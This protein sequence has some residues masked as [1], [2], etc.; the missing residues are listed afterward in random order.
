MRDKVSAGVF[1]DRDGVINELIFNGDT[2]EFEPPHSPYDLHI[3]PFA[4]ESLKR[5]SAGNYSLFLVSNQPDYAKGKTTL[6]NLKS[7]HS[8]LHKNLSEN[9]VE[10]KEYFYCYHHPDGVVVKYTKRC[11]CRKPS[12]FFLEKA[13]RKYSIDLKRSWLIGDRDTDI[14][15][16]EE[17]GVRSIMVNYEHSAGYRGNSSPDYQASNL[18]EAVNIILSS[19]NKIEQPG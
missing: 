5:L 13:E 1:L 11:K 3:F 2:S 10:F 9:G 8:A 15:M 7:V 16:A 4:V 6:E 12:P 19:T 18:H 17:C 14:L